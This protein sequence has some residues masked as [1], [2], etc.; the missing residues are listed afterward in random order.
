MDT[1]QT[2][3]TRRLALAQVGAA[4][5]AIGLFGRSAAQVAAQEAT[6]DTR[7]PVLVAFEAAWNANDDGS[8]FASLL[9]PDVVWEDVPSGLLFHGPEACAAYYVA[10]IQATPDLKTQYTG[11]PGTRQSPSGRTTAP[12]RVSFPECPRARVSQSRSEGSTFSRSKG[13]S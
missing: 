5:L 9:T 7:P 12:T 3:V 11:L 2:R 10:Q 1:D 4:S 8:E 13:T 6:P